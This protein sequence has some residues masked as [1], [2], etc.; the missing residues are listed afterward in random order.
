[1]NIDIYCIFDRY[2]YIFINISILPAVVV[3]ACCSLLLLLLVAPWSFIPVWL[4]HLLLLL[5]SSWYVVVFV[6]V[7]GGVGYDNVQ[8]YVAGWPNFGLLQVLSTRLQKL[9]GNWKNVMPRASLRKKNM[10]LWEDW[11][12]LA[13]CWFDCDWFELPQF[14]CL[15]GAVLNLLILLLFLPDQQHAPWSSGKLRP[16]AGIH[17]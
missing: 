2:I 16:F 6:V 14:A 15:F 9:P 11:F 4:E 3:V 17:E 7:G 8:Y 13:G 10:R 12:N 5:S 1:M